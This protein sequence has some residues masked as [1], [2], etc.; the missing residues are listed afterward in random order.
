MDVELALELANPARGIIAC[1]SRRSPRPRPSRNPKRTRTP[2][3]PEAPPAPAPAPASEAD[4]VPD[5]LFDEE[6]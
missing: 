6:E 4:D 3:Q 2:K 1:S 5:D